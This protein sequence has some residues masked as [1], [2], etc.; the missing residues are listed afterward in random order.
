MT[1]Y[2][3]APFLVRGLMEACVGHLLNDFIIQ[4]SNNNT[5]DIRFTLTIILDFFKKLKN[6]LMTRIWS[7]HSITQ[8]I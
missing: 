3:L 1:Y 8:G 7:L 2:H 5:M 6:Y 4:K